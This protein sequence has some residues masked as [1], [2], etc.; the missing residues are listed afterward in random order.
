MEIAGFVVGAISMLIAAASALYA[1]GANARADEANRVAT[2]ALDLQARI[3]SREREY[4]DV[5][6]SASYKR[7]VGFTLTNEG[8]TEARE[9]VLVLHGGNERELHRVG[10]VAHGQSATVV[11]RVAAEWMRDNEASMPLAPAFTA[12][13]SS[14]LGVADRH[15][16]PPTGLFI[17]TKKAQ[18]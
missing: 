15:Y 6:W 5:T 18:K 2:A 17:P 10:D 3:D 12:H 11:S 16:S 1:K 14:P 4:R 7:D 9:V 13:W 8:L